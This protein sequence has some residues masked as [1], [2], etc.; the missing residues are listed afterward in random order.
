MEPQRRNAA[1]QG[2][3]LT[4]RVYEHT[5]SIGRQAKAGGSTGYTSEDQGRHAED[6]KE[7][8]TLLA[9]PWAAGVATIEPQ[10]GW[11]IHSKNHHKHGD[12][13]LL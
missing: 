6:C 3:V 11:G 5:H 4:P 9:T 12:G 1:P 13:S 2:G 8:A 7:G 10:E